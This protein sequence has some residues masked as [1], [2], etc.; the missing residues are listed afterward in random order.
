[1]FKFLRKDKRTKV[2]ENTIPK[3][4]EK[5]QEKLMVHKIIELFNKGAGRLDLEFD[6]SG[7][8][9]ETTLKFDN[10]KILERD[11]IIDRKYESVWI[12]ITVFDKEKEFEVYESPEMD[13]GITNHDEILITRKNDNLANALEVKW[14]H[15][16]PW[17]EHITKEVNNLI[18]K[19]ETIIDEEK[20]RKKNS[21]LQKIKENK[22]HFNDVFSK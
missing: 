4:P 13:Y 16:G 18:Q 12:H 6:S 17:C 22:D 21:E 19:V 2:V 15:K 5:P 1:M 10:F 20:K 9:Q 8:W 7:I 11:K 3:A 14:K